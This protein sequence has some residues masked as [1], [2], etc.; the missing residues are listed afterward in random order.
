MRPPTRARF[1]RELFSPVAGKVESIDNRRLAL[2]G[3][4][5][6]VCIGASGGYTS[7]GTGR[8]EVMSG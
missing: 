8:F 4:C 3:M 7:R 1:Q 2:A 5:E 6:W